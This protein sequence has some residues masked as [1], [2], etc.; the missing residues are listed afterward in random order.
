MTYIKVE[1]ESSNYTKI[2]KRPGKGWFKLG[3]FVDWFR[4]TLFYHKTDKEITG[5]N[6]MSKEVSDYS[7]AEKEI[8]FY[9]KIIKE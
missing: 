1:K 2:D 3:W 6:K 7:K 4:E 5:Y 8:T 9:S